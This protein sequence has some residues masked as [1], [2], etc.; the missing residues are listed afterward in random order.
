MQATVKDQRE[1]GNLCK[2]MD[3]MKEIV[4]ETKKDLQITPLGS[5]ERSPS[6]GSMRLY[7]VITSIIL[8]G[9]KRR[10]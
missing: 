4:D 10:N 9:Y 7:R 1:V 2:G 8:C 5:V 3:E 6:P